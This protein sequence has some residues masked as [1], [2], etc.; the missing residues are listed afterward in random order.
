MIIKASGFSPDP[1]YESGRA[2]YLLGST[3]APDDEI[4]E[5]LDINPYPVHRG[6]G[7][8]YSRT[9]RIR[10]TRTRTLVIVETGLDV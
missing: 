2:W 7:L 3:D 5:I 9:P 4:L 8:A 10:R 6:P 1:Y